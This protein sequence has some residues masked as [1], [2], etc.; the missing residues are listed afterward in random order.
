[1]NHLLVNLAQDIDRPVRVFPIVLIG[2]GH[3]TRPETRQRVRVAASTSC[4]SSLSAFCLG[5]VLG[6]MD[7]MYALTSPP[8]CSTMIRT[9]SASRGSTLDSVSSALGSLSMSIIT[10]QDMY[11]VPG[12]RR[13]TTRCPP[14]EYLTKSATGKWGEDPG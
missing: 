10:Q 7:S 8:Y 14:S 9:T 2:S 13:A 6:L 3:W 12:M 4:R 1:M 11:P 5:S